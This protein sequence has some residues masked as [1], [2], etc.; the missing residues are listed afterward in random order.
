VLEADDFDVRPQGRL[1]RGGKKGR[2]VLSPFSVAHDQLL[3]GE[4]DV[5][6]AELQRL[7]DADSGAVDQR[8]AQVLDAGHSRE[9]GAD[10]AARE[11]HGQALGAFRMDDSLQPGDLP[12]Q[13]VLV[14]K[15]QRGQRLILGRSAYVPLGRERAQ[16]GG[17]FRLVQSGGMLAVVEVDESSDPGDVALFGATAVVA[18]RRTA[19]TRSRSRGGWAAGGWAA[20]AWPAGGRGNGMMAADTG[21]ARDCGWRIPALGCERRAA[22]RSPRHR[23]ESACGL[24]F[25]I[26]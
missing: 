8:R 11:D 1:Q 24:E 2:A 20:E 5:L 22:T 21:V 10:L 6:D 7:Q 23:I 4:V 3:A 17:D 13:H 15:E 16:E 9:D 19:R 25:G 18:A 14:E 12:P 26:A